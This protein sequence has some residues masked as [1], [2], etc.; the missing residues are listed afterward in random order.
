MNI[1]DANIPLEQRDLL[2]LA[3]IPCRAI[4]LDFAEADIGDDNII[5]LLH[6]LRQPTFFTRDLHFYRRHLCHACYALVHLD[7]AAEECA[8]FIR[9]FLRHPRFQTKARRMGLVARVH[10]D[11]VAFWQ[12]G[13]TSLQRVPWNPD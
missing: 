8:L 5:T 6:R 12:L 13:G 9:R 4:G 7:L 10:H 1:L 3:G 11:G 2:Q